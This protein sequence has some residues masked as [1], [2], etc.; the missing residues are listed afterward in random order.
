[1]ARRDESEARVLRDRGRDGAEDDGADLAPR[2]E[3]AAVH[4]TP[5][6]VGRGREGKGDV[7]E[8]VLHGLRTAEGEDD[9]AGGL[10]DGEEARVVGQKG[11]A[12]WSVEVDMRRKRSCGDVLLEFGGGDGIGGFDQGA[13]AGR[14][15][16]LRPG[17]VV[18]ADAVGGGRVLRV[19]HEIVVES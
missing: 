4:E 7:G 19:E 17:R 15:A 1:M 10:R 18:V 14:A 8:E 5:A 12:A 16:E 13:I 2:G 11:A 9:G 6:A 3:E